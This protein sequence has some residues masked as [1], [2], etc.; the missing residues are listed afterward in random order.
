MKIKGS[1]IAIC[2]LLIGIAIGFYLARRVWPPTNVIGIKFDGAGQMVV[3]AKKGDRLEW[4]DNYGKH[5]PVEMELP[6]TPPCQPPTKI[7][8][9]TCTLTDSALY[10]FKCKFSELCQDPAWGGGDDT[11]L[12]SDSAAA[13]LLTPPLTTPA[14]LVKVYCDASTSTATADPTAIINGKKGDAFMMQPVG[15]GGFSAD[16]GT[17]DPCDVGPLN[18]SN[19][20]CRI[21]PTVTTNIVY[22]YQLKIDGCAKPGNGTITVTP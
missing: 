4:F 9:G 11:L 6:V 19:Q 2:V 10:Y 18:G 7:E 12:N 14:H 5:T 1:G 8:N 17:N 13:S 16:F 20:Y 22:P 15:T 3:K 21:T